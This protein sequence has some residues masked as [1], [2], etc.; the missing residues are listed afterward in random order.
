ME[1]IASTE[2]SV[3][4]N[5]KTSHELSSAGILEEQKADEESGNASATAHIRPAPDPSNVEIKMECDSDSDVEY[6]GQYTLGAPDP[7]TP[8]L[9][10]ASEYH[11]LTRG[12]DD[13]W[14]LFMTVYKPGDLDV[15][16]K[17]II[18]TENLKL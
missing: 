11:D 16:V 7:P 13:E 18:K 6:V 12:S 2:D 4:M 3:A 1:Q 8:P 17:P 15:D 14:D 10:P 9:P 5:S